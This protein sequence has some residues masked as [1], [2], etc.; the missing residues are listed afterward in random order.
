MV[1]HHQIQKQLILLEEL[2]N[3]FFHNKKSRKMTVTVLPIV[4][5]FFNLIRTKKL[6]HISAILQIYYKEHCHKK[7]R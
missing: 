6:E 4:Y 2:E 5:M 1:I 7:N 3:V